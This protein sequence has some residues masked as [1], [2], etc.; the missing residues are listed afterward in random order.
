M[1]VGCNINP[2]QLGSFRKVYC[3]QR[4][5]CKWIISRNPSSALVSQGIKTGPAHVSK[6]TKGHLYSLCF[7]EEHP[8]FGKSLSKVTLF[9]SD[10]V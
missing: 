3:A 7:M 5:Q 8:G 9:V 4:L 2:A 10:R 6:R 1:C